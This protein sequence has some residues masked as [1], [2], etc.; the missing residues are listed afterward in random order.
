M[1]DNLFIVKEGWP[2]ESANPGT[3]ILASDNWDDFTYKT[4][5][6]LYYAKESKE[7]VEIGYVKIAALGTKEGDPHTKL[8]AAFSR[9]SE[10]FFSLGQ[11]R[12][13]YENLM[14]LPNNKGTLALA[15]L[16]DVAADEKI[17]NLSKDEDVFE[18]SLLR[19]I[20]FHTV[21]SQ[22]KRITAGQ[23]P[24]TPYSFY[25]RRQFDNDT[26]PDLEL[27]FNVNP[28]SSPPT[29]VHVLIGANGV[30][31]SMMLRDMVDI[32]MGLDDAVGTLQ[33]DMSVLR[34]DSEIVPFVNVVHV[35]FS[36]FDNT[37]IQNT[38]F[39]NI[40]IHT[41][42]LPSAEHGTLDSQFSESFWVCTKEPRRKRLIEAFRALEYADPLLADV[43]LSG[44]LDSVSS[45]N[46]QTLVNRFKLMSSGH[47]IAVLTATRLVEL[48]EEQ[49]LVL[50]DEPEIHLHPPLLS[51][52]TRTI[53]DLVIDRN[54]V[55]IIA[56]HSPVVLQEV[57]R[58]CVWRLRRSGE[59]LRASRLDIESFGES[60]SKLTA[61]VFHLDIS[62]TSYHEILSK[63]IDQVGTIDAALDILDGQLGG[64]GRFLLNSIAHNRDDVDV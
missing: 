57:P 64:E 2:P 5:F 44:F 3:F 41:V 12:E 6:T 22:F 37:S 13:Y 52:L 21:S 53:S 28:D 10:K 61:E 1:R 19:E 51:A 29:N 31:K 16:N 20:P 50:I 17:L 27:V 40:R 54:G 42:G 33:N 8:P 58:S 18:K 34:I 46:E 7:V 48:V 35:S 62:K 43:G 47:K 38:L 25:Y 26:I 15:A 9:L 39:E 11:S 56:T 59:D 23:A 49:S 55:A 36:A 24:L 60:V 30:G 63:L 45:I 14:A 4:T 32:S